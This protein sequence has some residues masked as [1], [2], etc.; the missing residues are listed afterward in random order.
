[1]ERIRTAKP[2][3]KME[4]VKIWH[5][6]GCEVVHMSVGKTMINFSRDDFAAFTESVVDINYSGSWHASGSVIDLVDRDD[7]S[8]G[9]GLYH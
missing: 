8:F 5:C 7:D 6:R 9:S 2:V 3:S 1:M 4:N